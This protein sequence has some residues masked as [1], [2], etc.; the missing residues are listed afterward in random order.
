MADNLNL[1]LTLEAW[2]DI[3]IRNWE[4]KILKLRI[5]DTFSLASSF[6]S[7]VKTESNGDISRIEFVFNY[8]GKFID[9]GVGKGQE[10]GSIGSR[11][12]RKWYS[13]QF[14]S[15]LKKLNVIL[16]EKY[17]RKGQLAVIEKIKGE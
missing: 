4:D 8:Y 10:I 16:A 1:R 5:T 2:A 13:K 3:V 9:M 11:R 14:F 12:P 7:H 15:E 17:A 6:Q